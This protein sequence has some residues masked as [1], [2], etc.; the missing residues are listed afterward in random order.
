MARESL[1]VTVVLLQNHAYAILEMELARVG[2]HAPGGQAR[3]ML[4]LNDPQ[5][6]FAALAAGFGVPATV[7]TDAADFDRALAEG[8]GTPGPKVVVAPLPRL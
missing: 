6:D 7:A 8:L 5:L 3:R 4:E 2:A 1:D